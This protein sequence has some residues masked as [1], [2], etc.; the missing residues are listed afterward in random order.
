MFYYF[1]FRFDLANCNLND[2]HVNKMKSDRVPDV[3][4]LSI[5]PFS[6]VLKR[7]DVTLMGKV[8]KVTFLKITN[9]FR[10]FF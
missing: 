7:T 8:H 4:R 9:Q 2:E 1:H 3:V 5:F 10:D 6:P